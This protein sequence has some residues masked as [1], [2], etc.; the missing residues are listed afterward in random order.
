VGGQIAVTLGVVN[1]SARP[2]FADPKYASASAALQPVRERIPFS[3]Q[4]V[5]NRREAIA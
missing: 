3:I 5:V 1:A 4:P 2:S